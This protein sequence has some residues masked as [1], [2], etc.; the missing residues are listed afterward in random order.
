[1]TAAPEIRSLGAPAAT[2]GEGPSCDPLTGV[3]HWFDILGRRLFEHDP[4]SGETR[5][6]PLP[7]R[8]SAMAAVD[9]AR[10][11][12]VSETGLHLRDR[13]TGAL[14]PHLAIEAENTATRSNDA[15]THPSGAFW[16]GTMGLEAERGAGAIYWYRD[17]ALR[18]LFEGITVP[19]SICF[20]PDGATGYFSDSPTGVIRRVPLDP[21][22]GLPAG[23]ARPF[24]A[25]RGR[26]APDGAVTDAEGC[27]W[28]ARWDGACIE[29]LSPE[30][31]LMLTYDLPVP[32][33]TCPAFF[34]PDAA[35]LLVTSAQE[36]LDAAALAET[37]LSG[38]TLELLLPAPCPGRLDAPVRIG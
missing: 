15:R 12:L 27:L 2:L 14:T 6:H 18:T 35:R 28:V 1:M 38:E 19:N 23:E 16:I 24:D 21:A 33:P 37:P 31:A 17:G 32:R 30:G 10:Q 29:R 34:G 26:G 8:A 20:S 36:G 13:A 25:G 3:V 5:E 9:G 7:M 11:L 22:T 4:E